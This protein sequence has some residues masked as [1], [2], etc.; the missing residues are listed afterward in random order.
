MVEKNFHVFFFITFFIQ[1]FDANLIAKM[2]NHLPDILEPEK[3]EL[4]IYTEV[5]KD[6]PDFH[7]EVTITVS[8]HYTYFLFKT[9]YQAHLREFP[10]F[11]QM[12]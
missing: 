5:M 7:G 9:H 11:N 3:Y 10:L 8:T 2:K 1:Q 12:D 6:E 4:D